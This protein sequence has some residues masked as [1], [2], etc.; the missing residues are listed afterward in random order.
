MLTA[1]PPRPPVAVAQEP[2]PARRPLVPNSVAGTMMFVFTEIML[3]AGLISAHM[4]FVSNQVGELWPPPDQPLLPF[5]ETARNSVF[6]LL[7]GATL[8]LAWRARGRGAGVVLMGVTTLLGAIF[9]AS[10]GVEWLGL[11]RDGLT[12][13][14]SPY[15]GFFYMIVGAHA[16]HAV[17]GILCLAWAWTSLRADRLSGPQFVSVQIFWY[18][19]VLVWPVIFLQVYR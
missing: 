8:A 2:P 12:L 7:S 3:F 11:I 1:A 18:F 17:A 6:L 19:V 15:G 16:L 10:Q 14:S 4:V 9:V 13:T 5:A